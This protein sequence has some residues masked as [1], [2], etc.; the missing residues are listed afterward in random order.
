MDRNAYK[1]NEEE[2]N[3]LVRTVNNEQLER[4]I[5]LLRSRN[6][7]VDTLGKRAQVDISSPNINQHL[8][9]NTTGRDNEQQP[10]PNHKSANISHNFSIKGKGRFSV[11]NV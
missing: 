3:L 1:L 2:D 8:T 11:S 5:M 6:H 7:N 4:K 9:E 10:A